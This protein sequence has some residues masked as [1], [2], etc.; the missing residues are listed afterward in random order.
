MPLT[1]IQLRQLKPRD[2]DY[3]TADGGGLYVHVSKTGSKLWRLRY[4]FD[5][6]EKLLAF[7]LFDCSR[8]ADQR[9]HA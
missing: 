3:K 8:Q 7:P 4:R 9:K 5:G 2:K 1:D 6:K